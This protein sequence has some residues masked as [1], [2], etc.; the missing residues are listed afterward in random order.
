M[1]FESFYFN[2]TTR[3]WALSFDEPTPVNPPVFDDGDTRD[4]GVTFLQTIGSGNGSSSV[5]VVQSVV[6]ARFSISNPST[7]ASPITSVSSSGS[8]T[9]DF[10]LLLPMPGFTSFLSG[11]S[12]SSPKLAICQFLITTATG[13]NSYDGL[14]FIRPSQYTGSAP[15]ATPPQRFLDSDELAG[16]FMPKEV[17]AGTRMIWTDEVTGQK[18]AVGFA[19]GQLRADLL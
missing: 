12:L 16:A 9:N 18:Y 3:E 6:A 1:P 15:T 2:L 19:N 17:P 8:S 11:V 10:A 14:I 7:P 4:F 5:R 13:Q